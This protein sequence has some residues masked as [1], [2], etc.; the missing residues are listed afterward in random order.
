MKLKRLF[1]FTVC[2]CLLS[3]ILISGCGE[4]EPKAVKLAPE[5][6][7]PAEE[8]AE[9]ELEVPAEPQI[10]EQPVE[11]G[12]NLSLKFSPRDIATYQVKTIDIQEVKWEGSV[13]KNSKFTD[14]QNYRIIIITFRQ[15][16][17]NVDENGVA[18]A[19]IT[20]DKLEF[21][22]V[23]KNETKIVFDSTKD[24][25]E[26]FLGGLIDRSYTISITPN[27]E[28]EVIDTKKARSGLGGPSLTAQAALGLLEPNAIKRR[29][30]LLLLPDP[31]QNPVT[32]QE[33]WSKNETYSFGLMGSN[34]YEKIYTFKGVEE[35][36][37]EKAALVSM[38]A[39]P[40]AGE[41]AQ[42][43]GMTDM[44]NSEE[45]YAGWLSFDLDRGNVKDYSEKLTVQWV[46]LMPTSN[47]QQAEPAVLRM[48][49]GRSY[50]LK[51]ID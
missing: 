2:F 35:K 7:K 6:E 17:L 5:T 9:A 13:P 32:P 3:L 27:G 14:G 33:Q 18:K 41:A 36:D 44:F 29:H 30:S 40:G 34:S 45:K 37:D 47:K 15:K 43:S 8:I 10:Q 48:S 4:A 21:R 11:S 22:H 49:A 39:I 20:I 19:R 26:K 50:D 23:V 38:E 42:S 46:S 28:A 16:I 25:T 51:R 1:C 24:S 12:V 31:N